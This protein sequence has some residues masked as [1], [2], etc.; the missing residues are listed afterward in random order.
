MSSWQ[1]PQAYTCCICALNFHFC[2]LHE[3]CITTSLQILCIQKVARSRES[4]GTE[5]TKHGL[6][7]VEQKHKWPCSMYDSL[8]SRS[9]WGLNC[10]SSSR[11]WRDI[12]ARLWRWNLRPL[13]KLGHKRLCILGNFSYQLYVWNRKNTWP[14]ICIK[15]SYT[16]SVNA[17]FPTLLCITLRSSLPGLCLN[18]K[19]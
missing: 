3:L 1:S 2:M 18:L 17:F 8:G 11:W 15:V 13:Q 4:I 14:T 7:T 12:L 10:G 5:T 6:E 16:L 9:G 19:R